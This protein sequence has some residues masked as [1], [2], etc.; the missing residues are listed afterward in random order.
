MFQIPFPVSFVIAFLFLLPDGLAQ[1]KEA[2]EASVIDRYEKLIQH[3]RYDNPDSASYYAELGLKHSVQNHDLEGEAKMLHQMGM[4]D[5]N[6]GNFNDSRQ[7]YLRAL[8]L[9]KELKIYSGVSKLN[10]RLGVVENR[11]GNYDKAIAYF[12]IALKLSEK[13]KNKAGIMEAYVTLGEVYAHQK[14]FNKAL[15]YYKMA[16]QLSEQVPFFNITLNMYNDMGVCYTE[17]RNYAAAKAYL[18]KGIGLSNTKEMM[19]LHISMTNN[20]ARVYFDSGDSAMAIKLYK[21]ALKKSREIHNFIREV[22]SLKGLAQCYKRRNPLVALNYLDQA[23]SLAKQKK[24]NKIVLELLDVIAGLQSELGDYKAAYLAKQQQYTIADSFYYKEISERISS[25]QAQYELGK[26]KA[27]V[28][29]LKFLNNQQKL[30]RRILIVILSCTVVII[31]FLGFYFIKVRKLNL[32]LNKSNAALSSSNNVKDKLFSILGHDLRSPIAS[33]LN[34]LDL[35]N[36]GMLTEEE[37]QMIMKKL[38]LNC[39]TSMETLDLLLKWGQMQLKGILINQVEFNALDLLE[40]NLQA[41][42]ATAEEKSITISNEL[43]A[44]VR[45]LADADHFDFI[46]RNL[47]SN[48]IKFTPNGGAVVVWAEQVLVEGKIERMKFCVQDNGI[49]IESSRLLTI[50]GIDNVSTNGTNNEKGTSLGLVICKE[51]VEANG[52]N[53]WVESTVGKGA[54]FFFTLKTAL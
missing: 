18:T 40:R 47:V 42:Q 19:G 35:I 24:A 12:F 4:I 30:E 16:E 43:S 27:D 54:K 8:E 17:M 9:Y 10:V 31:S 20:L 13:T 2:A 29:E 52:G 41:L 32:L 46:C 7:K 50:F 36:E 38:A 3:Y 21:D 34:V 39:S 49:G 51:F 14:N 37:Q 11:K 23:L 6:L 5:D 25:L 44:D 1:I 22:G 33:I 26:S 45:L 28:Q 15:V 53:I 48:A